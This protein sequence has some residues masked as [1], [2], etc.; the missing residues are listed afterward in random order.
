[1]GIHTEM[2]KESLRN[3]LWREGDSI[4]VAVSGGPDSMALLHMLH[5][6]SSACGLQI[7]AAHVNHGFR[8]ESAAEL[9]VVRAYA[10][11]LGVPCETAELELREYIAD[12]RLNL[13]AAARE[14][15]YQFLHETASRH[16]AACIAL[17]HHADDQAET[18]MMRIIRGAGLTGLAAMSMKRKEKNVELIRPLLRMYKSDLI[19][20]CEDN[21]VPYCTDSSNA[22]RYYFRNTVRLDIL[23]FLTAYNPQL[24]QSLVR[25]ADVAGEEDDWMESQAKKWFQS[26]VQCREAECR[27]NSK[28]FERLHVALQ[29][30]MIKLILRYL[31]PDTDHI[32]FDSVEKMRHAALGEAGSTWR[33]DAGAGIR[34][35]LE[36]GTMRWIREDGYCGEQRTSEEGFS[37]VIDRA[38][39][40]GVVR[41]PGWR[42]SFTLK[43]MSSDGSCMPKSRHEACFDADCLAWP[44]QVRNRKQGDRI[45][46]LG[47]NGS[48]KVQDM[49]V[50][51][52]IPPS[53]RE[54]YPLLTDAEDALLWVPGIRRSGLALA[55]S[56]MKLALFVAADKE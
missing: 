46:V 1:M 21:A 27:L 47:L 17:A 55:Q 3:G 2:V 37:F 38:D 9:K 48:K 20:Y 39:I 35:M 36:Y 56:G 41:T 18:V 22:E 6:A 42:L 54:R 49:F 29:R 8:E 14:K 44:L 12:N 28:A 19:A 32:S 34:C 5:R 13:Q 11:Q 16:D 4:V 33:M 30:R 53:E 7:V 50:D 40:E 52:K 51:E 31:S 25:L 45:Q 26:H 23:P 43:P 15:R 10:A 24:S